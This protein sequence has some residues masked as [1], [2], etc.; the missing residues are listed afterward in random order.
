MLKTFLT[1]ERLLKDV[2]NL[3]TNY[4][5]WGKNAVKLKNGQKFS[6]KCWKCYVESVESGVD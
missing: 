3:W 6:T 2:E 4:E 1:V 5:F